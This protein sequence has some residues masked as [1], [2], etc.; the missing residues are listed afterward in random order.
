MKKVPI[1]TLVG[2][3]A[4]NQPEK[5][6]DSKIADTT[7]AISEPIL[8]DSI[9]TI[10]EKP[11]SVDSQDTLIDYDESLYSH[12]VPNEID[13][14]IKTEL[15]GWSLPHPARWGKVW[16]N[17]YKTQHTLVNFTT[18]D[19]NCDQKKDYAM[20]MQNQVGDLAVWLV[21]A[22][23]KGFEKHK[24]TEYGKASGPIEI[25]LQLLP[26]GEYNQIE[27]EE[28]NTSAVTFPCQAIQVIAFEK[29][30]EAYY[31][32]KAGYKSIQT[33]D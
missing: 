7:F 25:G 13:S 10:K 26:P 4:C 19:F 9:G 33:G 17:D 8:V 18:G 24:L 29:S 12:Y 20:L 11:L 28:E 23:D 32:D 21:Q 6:A 15:K 22:V 2:F 1:V 30:A 14:F 27:L 3:L 16:F 5:Q 31:W